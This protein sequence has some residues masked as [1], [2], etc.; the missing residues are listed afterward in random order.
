MLKTKI[1]ET[2]LNHYA[3]HQQNA[4][5]KVEITLY[6]RNYDGS[7]NLDVG[8][9]LINNDMNTWKLLKVERG[10]E[11]KIGEFEEETTGLLGLYIIAEGQLYKLPVDQR[12]RESLA[13]IDDDMDA[14]KSILEQQ[15][16]P[17]YFSADIEKE[18]AINLCKDQG[19]YSVYYLFKSGEKI[20][21]SKGRPLNS[22]SIIAYNFCLLLKKFDEFFDQ[23]G[24]ELDITQTEIDKVK[25]VYFGKN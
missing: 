19:K 22:A 4:D 17:K 15:I 18:D 24:S 9:K 16:H 13:C 6:P 8:Y 3:M 14:V 20:F 12:V 21:F 11:M 10:Q 25:K 1:Y 5:G 23:W 7:A 2:L